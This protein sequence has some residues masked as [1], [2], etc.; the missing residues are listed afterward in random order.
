MVDVPAVT[1]VTVPPTTVAL[2][3]LLLHTPPEVASFRVVVRPVQT[4]A[5]A[6][7]IAAGALLTVATVVA[8]QPAIV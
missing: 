7:V 8:E 1:P 6:G 2:P 3:L 4:E 5:V